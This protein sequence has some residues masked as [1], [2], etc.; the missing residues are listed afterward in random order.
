M[1]GGETSEPDA[2]PC[3]SRSIQVRNR[4]SRISITAIIH[5]LCII[6]AQQTNHGR[7]LRP[8]DS[9]KPS[10]FARAILVAFGIKTLRAMH[11]A[12]INLL[13]RSL[14]ARL[15]AFPLLVSLSMTLAAAASAQEH[16]LQPQSDDAEFKK[17]DAVLTVVRNR[18]VQE[19]AIT[20]PNGIDE[21]KYVEIGGIAQWI[22]IRGEDRTNPVLLLL[23]GGPGDATNPWGYAGFRSWLKHFT[24]VQWDQRGAGKTFGRSGPSLA[25]TITIERMAQD[26]IEL[27]SLL[28]RTLH[29]KKIVLVGH[30]WGSILGVFVVKER[31]DLFYAFVGTGQVVDSSRN[32]TVAYDALLKKAKNL[33]NEHAILELNEIGHPPY[34]DGK[35]YRVQRKW[36]NLFEG[37]DFFLSSTLS[38]ALAAPGYSLRDVNDWLDGQGLSSQ[39]LVPQTSALDPKKLGGNFSVPV[40]VIQGAEDFTTPT[41]LAKNFVNSIR[42][43]RKAFVQIRGGGHFAVYMKSDEFLNEL[44]ARVRPLARETV[45]LTPR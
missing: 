6:G 29:K 24:V 19:Y 35:G 39:Q 37:A 10:A 25:P 2:R 17:L 12:N 11:A 4:I 16:T 30:S 41:S 38:F 9:Q 3:D 8:L 26:A 13:K 44:V 7:G 27:T 23:H 42:A 18:N 31:P 28:C 14:A 22:T 45:G 43:P 20:T 15:G 32:Y 33:G 21:A 36:S 5:V 40:F 34:K 1:V